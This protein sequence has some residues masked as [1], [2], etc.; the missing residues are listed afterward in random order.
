MYNTEITGAFYSNSNNRWAVYNESGANMIN[1]SSYNIYI[2][3]G[4][5][6][7]LHIADI[8]NQGSVDSY[9]VLNHPDLNGNPN[10]NIILTGYYNPNSLR[11]NHPYGVWYD[12]NIDRWIIYSEDFDTI[13]L[14]TAFFVKVDG[15]LGQPFK[16]VA[17]AGNIAGNYTTIDHP[18]L[19]G[20]PDAIFNFSHNWGI[21][22][23]SS[24][25]IIDKATGVWYTGSNW[26]IYTE[27]LSA[28]PENAEFDL[29]IFDT[30]LSVDEQTSLNL[31]YYPNPARDF[32]NINAA[33]TIKSVTVF[34]IL[35]KKVLHQDGDQNT[36]R[37][38]TSSL[39][40]GSYLAQVESEDAT[41]VI[42]FIKQ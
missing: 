14:D 35:G 34:D 16:H 7:V 2:A 17:T 40:V 27:D 11:N 9:S 37:L 21:S 3:Q 28:M 32:M 12:V 19:N 31:N 20:N 4:S 22:G 1:G 30:T 5:E 8:A 41:Q 13:P 24:N 29:Y 18:L 39:S 23:A 25:V 26:A 36:V 38:N 42:K 10:A 33:T 6:V 15:G